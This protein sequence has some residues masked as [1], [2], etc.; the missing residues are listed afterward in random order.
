MTPARMAN[1]YCSPTCPAVDRAFVDAWG[2]MENLIAPSL[3]RDAESLLD[4]LLN[5][6]KSV[7]TEKLRRALEEVCA[8]LIEAQSNISDL[9]KQV[10]RLQDEVN[11]MEAT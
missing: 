5:D 7:G 4:S 2:D 6:I 3:Q 1:D 8:E 10:E 9:E 11:S